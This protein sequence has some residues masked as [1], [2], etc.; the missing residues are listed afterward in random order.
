MEL[1]RL[2]ALV[3]A[4][5]ALGWPQTDIPGLLAK[6]RDHQAELDRLRED[7][8]YTQAVTHVETDKTGKEKKR[9]V[10]TYEVTYYRRRRI[11][12]LISV[13]GKP[14]AVADAAKEQRRVERLIRDLGEGKNPPDPEANRKL[15][16]STLL[17]AERFSRPRKESLHG[18]EVIVFDFAADPAFRPANNA[19]SFY[20]QVAG[21][22]WVDEADLQVARVEFR[23][24]GPF[25]AGGGAL[26]E[27]KPGA[28]FVNEQARF[29]D[30][31]WL[32]VRSEAVF[33][34]RA[35][36]VYTFGV[37]ETVEF[38]DY[39]RFSVKAEDVKER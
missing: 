4:G 27:M 5:A 34:A 38:R 2:A 10:K 37:R 6:V 25:K 28:T 33:Q 17:R 36:L 19:E 18:R 20:R 8:A 23:L 35:A 29:F 14:L 7:Y 15:Q 30:R 11:E 24:I 21:T 3:L 32:P 16:L 22:L 31:I 9:E 39:R 13:D 12:R 26:F 1:S